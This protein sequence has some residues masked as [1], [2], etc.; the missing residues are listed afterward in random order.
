M[1][2]LQKYR[3]RS[4]CS[5][6]ST[7][8][9]VSNDDSEMSDRY[10]ERR[11]AIRGRSKAGVGD[12]EK[13]KV[14]ERL[15]TLAHGSATKSSDQLG[16]KRSRWH[17]RGSLLAAVACKGEFIRS[18]LSLSFFLRGRASQRPEKSLRVSSR[19]C[20]PHREREEHDGNSGR[21]RRHRRRRERGPRGVHSRIPRLFTA[22]DW[23][24]S[25]WR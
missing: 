16:V 7:K 12:G 18:Q 4:R 6:C 20:T 24:S 5:A 3:R 14:I 2:N 17:V 9:V 15:W 25:D 1:Q 23:R 22:L 10:E 13:V 19:P 11:L 8:T 21:R